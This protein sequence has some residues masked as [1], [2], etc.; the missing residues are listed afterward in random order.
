MYK[1]FTKRSHTPDKNNKFESYVIKQELTFFNLKG[2]KNMDENKNLLY[3]LIE[4]LNEQEIIFL[5][6][7]INR[8]FVQR[9]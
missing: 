9:S 8:L 2:E 3:K 6:T 7:L 4:K 5:L 1:V